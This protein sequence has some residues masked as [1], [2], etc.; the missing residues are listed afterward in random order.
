MFS[1]PMSELLQ[2]FFPGGIVFTEF[3]A[4]DRPRGL[5]QRAFVILF[6]WLCHR[7]RSKESDK[8]RFPYGSFRAFGPP[9]PLPLP[10]P[11][12][13]PPSPSC[14]RFAVA[15]TTATTVTIPPFLALLL[16]PFSVFPRPRFGLSNFFSNELPTIT[17]L[18]EFLRHSA[19]RRRR[20]ESST[21]IYLR[22]NNYP[23]NS[24]A[25]LSNNRSFDLTNPLCIVHHVLVLLFIN[26]AL[27]SER[28]HSPFTFRYTFLIKL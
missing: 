28:E 10:L 2:G 9:L 25:A 11:P 18:D 23:C 24:L 8:H 1:N 27:T 21:S 5:T 16:F 6:I 17:R 13:P 20:G 12:T 19:T 26:E 3:R 4:S 22:E 14:P 15:D 7:S